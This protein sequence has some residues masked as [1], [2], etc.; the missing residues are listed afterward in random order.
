[1]PRGVGRRTEAPQHPVAEDQGQQQAGARPERQTGHQTVAG[2]GGDQDLQAR[3]AHV[4]DLVGEGLALGATLGIVPARQ[5]RH[6]ARHHLGRER[7][8]PPPHG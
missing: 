8:A 1:M 3:A 7:R 5:P 4:L 2:E 6:L